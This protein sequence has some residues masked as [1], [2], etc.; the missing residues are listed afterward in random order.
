MEQANGAYAER[1][2]L[3]APIGR[4]APIVGAA[5]EQAGLACAPCEDLP[6]LL[7]E[8]PRG[9][10]A[11]VLVEEVLPTDEAVDR[12]GAV[13]RAQP[14]WSDLPV[15]VFIT[16]CQRVPRCFE[17][18][19]RLSDRRGVT[20]LERP[21]SPP[22]L[23]SILQT[24]L[25][26][27]RRQYE[28]RDTLDQLHAA[29][30]ELARSNQELE[31]FARTLAHEVRSPLTAVQ[32]CFHLLDQRYGHVLDESTR[33]HVERA[34]HT[35]QGI[36]ALMNDLL[37][38]ARLEGEESAEQVAT[39]SEAALQNALAEL[40]AAL[41]ERGA[42]VT[43]GALPEVHAHPG[44]LR[45]VFRNLLSNAIKYNEAEV[46]RVH[47]EAE[48]TGGRWTFRVED[49]GIGIAEADRQ[50][51][52]GLFERAGDATHEGTGV[53]LAL[54]QRIVQQHGGRIWVQPAP[55]RGSTFLFTLPPAPAEG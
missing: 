21:I 22:T 31:G 40:E 11:V 14:S 54:C 45:R 4:T 41:A 53:G 30:A 55:G 10:G 33:G 50:R 34:A 48:R 13:L 35:L 49:N 51:I 1:V 7:R 26:T 3:L 29:N 23:V 44:Q 52:F 18:L 37:A 42:R 25:R 32:L 47:V 2:L 16:D 20:V 43:H 24:A 9:A 36:G 17:R 8:I 5:L 6:A 27:R 12:L 28:L 38:Y 39:S 19:Q 46:P 15:K